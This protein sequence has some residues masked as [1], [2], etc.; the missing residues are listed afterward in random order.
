MRNL[1][2]THINSC[3]RCHL[4]VSYIKT[5][6]NFK[7]RSQWYSYPNRCVKKQKQKKKQI[8]PKADGCFCLKHHL[9][10]VSRKISLYVRKRKKEGEKK[11]SFAFVL[12]F[13]LNIC[14]SQHNHLN[15]KATN[16]NQSLDL[17]C[18]KSLIEISW[19][20]NNAWIKHQQNPQE[21]SSGR[22]PSSEV[23]DL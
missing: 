1:N 19:K 18:K 13:A 3:S 2:A 5:M 9:K 20:I 12:V 16:Q 8:Q 11:Y 10:F 7:R 6:L 17:F 15:L 23:T 21:T 4:G 22:S 14:F